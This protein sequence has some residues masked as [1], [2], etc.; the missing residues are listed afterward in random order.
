MGLD[1]D[2]RIMLE[3]AFDRFHQDPKKWEEV[4]SICLRIQGIEPNLDDI[5]SNISG[6][7]E[8]FAVAF[9]RMQYNRKMTEKEMKEFYNFMKRRAWELR[10]AFIGTRIE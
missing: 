10:Q 8:G 9:Y 5:L 3:E 7:F 6:Y 1:R 2:L 4:I